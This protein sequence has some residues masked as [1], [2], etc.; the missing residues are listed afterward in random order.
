MTE[1]EHNLDLVAVV[2]EYPASN[3]KQRLQRFA[4]LP[5]GQMATASA[6][7]A[8]LG[9][10]ASYIGVF[11]DDELGRVSRESLVS[12]GVDVSA[13]WL[14]WPTSQRLIFDWAKSYL[15]ERYEITGVADILQRP[16]Y[17]WGEDAKIVKPGSPFGVYLFKRKD[18]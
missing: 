6:V 7:C 2:A 17:R 9:W 12:A 4:R 11:G 15:H 3:S 8:R 1:S 5:G 14:P 18:L 10:R 13:S 16:A